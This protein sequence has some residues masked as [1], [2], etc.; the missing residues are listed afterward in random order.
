MN[1]NRFPF[2]NYHNP[3][4]HAKIYWASKDKPFEAQSQDIDKFLIA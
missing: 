3:F 2:I 4:L 1:R